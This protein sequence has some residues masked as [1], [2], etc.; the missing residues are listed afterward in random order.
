MVSAAQ[1]V[2]QKFLV[3]TARWRSGRLRP[4]RVPGRPFK[5]GQG[6]WQES[7]PSRQ[8]LLGP[9]SAAQEECESGAWE[10]CRFALCSST[11]SPRVQAALG[12]RNR[13]FRM[14][15]WTFDGQFGTIL[16]HVGGSPEAQSRGASPPDLSRNLYPALTNDFFRFL[17]LRN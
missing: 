11:S 8:P 7:A 13:R 9:P 10:L 1:F 5:P 16:D 3:H 6:P 17:T 2:I 15:V 14:R 12:L 4:P